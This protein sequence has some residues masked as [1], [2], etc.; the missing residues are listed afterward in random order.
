MPLLLSAVAL[1]APPRLGGPLVDGSV[2]RATGC[3]THF[4]IAYRDEF[5]L[6][7]WLGGEMVKDNDVVQIND[8]QSSFEHEGQMTLTN[9]ATGRTIEVVI[10]Q[11]LMNHAD[12]LRSVERFCR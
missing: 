9:L 3:G 2:V 1:G 7:E 6:A 12:Y 5:V 8:E 11:T 10:E 4:F